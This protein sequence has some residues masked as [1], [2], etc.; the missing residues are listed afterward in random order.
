MDQTDIQKQNMHG[1]LNAT[2]LKLIAVVSMLIDHIGCVLF[3][4]LRW[5]RI[6]GRLAMPIYCFC[7]SEGLIHT[8]SRKD[9]LL[10]VFIFALVSEL[11]FDLAFN[12]GF[13]LGSQNVMFTFACAI[14][15]VDLCDYIRSRS[16]SITAKIFSIA[17]ALAFAAFAEVINTDYGIFGVVLVYFFYFFRSR[18]VLRL[19]AAVLFITV[20]CWGKLELYC[21][22]A[23]LL[24]AAYNGERGAGFKYLFYSFYPV[25]LTVLALID[26]FLF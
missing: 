8:R 10:R 6:I 22:P 19:A 25:H 14:P 4:S 12:G 20:T 18:P 15:G 21:L 17:A 24:L 13:E 16:S 5:L 1:F 2:A 9:Y 11:P 7:V 3:P 23:F 26:R